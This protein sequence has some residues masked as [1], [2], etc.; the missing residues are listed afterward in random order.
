[1]HWEQG[2]YPIPA[3]RARQLAKIIPSFPLLVFFAEGGAMATER[4]KRLAE[5]LYEVFK[6]NK[7]VF[8]SS[9]AADLKI[10]AQQFAPALLKQYDT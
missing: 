1:M 7:T 10:Y 2:I 6:A 8:K 9:F 5:A 4:E 3:T